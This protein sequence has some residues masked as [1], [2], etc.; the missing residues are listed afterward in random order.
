M[1]E[2]GSFSEYF[3]HFGPGTNEKNTGLFFNTEINSWKR[4]ISGYILSFV[5]G[6]LVS[7]YTFIASDFLV[8]NVLHNDAKYVNEYKSDVISMIILQP[9]IFSLL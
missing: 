7:Y 5:S 3:F 4:V 2:E 9:I 6:I 8:V 1:D